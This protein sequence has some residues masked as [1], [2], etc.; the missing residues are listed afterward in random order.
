MNA[1]KLLR[2]DHATVKA[3]FNRL[4]RTSKTDRER[5]DEFFNEVRR[6]LQIHSRVEEEI[7]YP[8]LKALD[9]EGQR[10]VSQALKEHQDI[11][12]L[13][14]L[15]SRLKTTD[16]MF[17]EQFEVLVENVDH[18]VEKEER[19]IFQFAEE[20]CSERQLEDLGRQI[21]ERKQILDRQMAA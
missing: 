18:H 4:I 13:L 9:G 21:D 15:I 5:K 10:L 7:F 2:K 19:E 11:D 14:I 1:L 12:Q 6:A 8:A 20:N 16:K 3:L 17:D